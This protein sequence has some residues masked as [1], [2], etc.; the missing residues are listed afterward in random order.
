VDFF[1]I[2]FD[3]MPPKELRGN[4]RAY[5]A[6]KIA[7]KRAFQDETIIK[8]REINPGFM[9]KI[10]I[11]YKAFYSGKPIDIDNLIT[12]MKYAQD[13]LQLEGVIEDDTP[14]HVISVSVEYQRVK[15]MKE[16]KLIMEVTKV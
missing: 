3:H 7:P 15:T 11:L 9:G 8:L 2:E 16:V 14:D 5:W 1:S 10:K 12:G 4:S 13:C 6:Q